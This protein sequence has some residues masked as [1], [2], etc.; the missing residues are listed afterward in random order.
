M[1]GVFENL[2]HLTPARVCV[3]V[4]QPAPEPAAAAASRLERLQWLR[5]HTAAPP[6]EP[7]P[8][9]V[10]PAPPSWSEPLP[11]DRAGPGGARR[12]TSGLRPATPPPGPPATCP[13]HTRCQLPIGAAAIARSQLARSP[14]RR[15]VAL[16][17]PARAAA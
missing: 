15:S 17:A 9:A 12:T 10:A 6:P 4:Q 11:A 7:A 1:G 14:D 16:P 2:G 8:P 13:P 3:H 5:D